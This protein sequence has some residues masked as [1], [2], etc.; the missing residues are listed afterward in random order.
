M[1]KPVLIFDYDGTIHNTIGI[2]EPAFRSAHE[3]LICE[4][5]TD[6]EVIETKRI[7]GWLG[8]NT[9]EM[10]NDFDKNLPQHYKD[11]ASSMVG[12]TMVELVR[13][14]QA[15]WYDGAEEALDQLKESGYDMI[16]LSN[17]KIA[18]KN[19]HMQEFGMDR[20][21][22]DFYD[23]ESRCFIPKTEIVK[24]VMKAHP[25]N[26]IVIGDRKHDL[27]CARSIGAPFIGCLYGFCEEGELDSADITIK[28]V[29]EL[30]E[31]IEKISKLCY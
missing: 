14:H 8:L 20:W 23:C 1:K 26:Y 18:Y 2:Y 9:K 12:N 15:K 30:P 31:A 13:S 5:V 7:A 21:F 6:D 27:Q 10:W 19:A 25:G 16:I 17:C 4:G 29:T 28:D 11:M 3:F 24:E 22:T